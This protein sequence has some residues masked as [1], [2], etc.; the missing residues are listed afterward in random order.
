MMSLSLQ[1]LVSL[2]KK[3]VVVCLFWYDQ[4][5]HLEF[6]L[7]TNRKK[8]IKLKIHSSQVATATLPTTPAIQGSVEEGECG[9][10]HY[11]AV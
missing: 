5:H 10:R 6:W 11:L 1:T 9:A 8:Q 2:L 3:Q 4:V 7:V